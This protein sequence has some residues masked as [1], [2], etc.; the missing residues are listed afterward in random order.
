[1]GFIKSPLINSLNIQHS[2]TYTDFLTIE[3]SWFSSPF[4]N[5]YYME[6]YR[7]KFWDEKSENIYFL[8][9]TVGKVIKIKKNQT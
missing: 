7:P 3:A 2:V 6:D 5:S 8:D 1:M 9:K 4:F